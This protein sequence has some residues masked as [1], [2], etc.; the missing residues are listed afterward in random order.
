MRYLKLA[1]IAALAALLLLTFTAPAYAA[2]AQPVDVGSTAPTFD[3]MGTYSAPDLNAA[4]GIDATGYAMIVW[5]NDYGRH[6]A[7]YEAT[8]RIPGGG[9]MAVGVSAASDIYPVGSRV[10]AIKPAEKGFIQLVTFDPYSHQISGKLS[11]DPGYK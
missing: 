9:F 1:A 10:I 2:P 3:M 11:H 5:D 8:E 7:L 6:T 4:I